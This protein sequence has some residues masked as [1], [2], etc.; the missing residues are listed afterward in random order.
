MPRSTLPATT[1]IHAYQSDRSIS[2]AFVATSPPRQC[3][4]A[5]F[6]NDLVEAIQSA[7]PA[8][9][10]EWAAIDGANSVTRYGPDVRWRI[11]QRHPDSYRQA[12]LDIDAAMVDVVNVQHEFGLYGDW[13][14]RFDDH[15]V[16]FLETLRTPLVTTLHSVPPDPTP[17]VREA[18]LRIGRHSH[19][20]V[21]MAEHARTLLVQRYGL[22]PEVVRVIP[23][24]VPAAGL[25]GRQTAKR[26]LGFEGRPVILTF[27]LID[28]RKGLEYMIGAMGAVARRYHDAAYV[29][30]GKTH[31][32]LRRQA[33][34]Q[35]RDELLAL[36]R[37]R[38]LAENVVFVDQ[39]L[40]QHQIVNYLSACD[41]YVTPYLDPNQITSGTLAYALGAGRAIVST[42]YLHALEVLSEQ[43]G[44]MVDFCSEHQLS[45]AVLTI[46]DDPLL[47]RRLEQRAFAYGSETYWPR[48]AESMLGL[49]R[50]AMAEGR[51]TA[52][53][54]GAH[55]VDSKRAGSGAAAGW[56]LRAAAA[57]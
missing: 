38:G 51:G 55:F 22:D 34:E 47:K 56:A 14:E 4:I 18:V 48:I 28:P 36:A 15:L 35:Y 45:E 42:P 13:G 7:R 10:L 43:R 31:P 49:Y 44:L 25:L 46:L 40:E 30:V 19:S 27:G 21:G 9:R 26:L 8:A 23:H 20:V 5:T 50:Q 16:P 29:I 33:G 32:E 12:A 17:S 41:V 24:G 6:T 57:R 54:S 53:A 52:G 2:L 3:G 39:F 11:R 37:S 1:P